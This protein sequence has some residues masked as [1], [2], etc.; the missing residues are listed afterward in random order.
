MKVLAFS[1]VQGTEGHERLFSDPTISLQRW[2]VQ[3]LYQRLQEICQERRCDAVFDLGDT[4][5]DRSAIPVHT[6]NT[7]SEGIAK[8][9]RSTWNVKLIGNHEQTVK[10]TEVNTGVLYRPRFRVVAG[11]EKIALRDGLTLLACSFPES[12]RDL[13]VWIKD[14]INHRRAGEKFLLIGHFQVSGAAMSS[15]ISLDGV[16]LSVLQPI[17]LGLLGHIHRGQSLAGNT[18][19][20]GS[21]FQQNFGESGETKRVAIIDTDTLMVEWVQ[22]EGFPEY[23]TVTLKEF[24]EQDSTSEDRLSVILKTPQEAEEFY[25]HPLAPRA[26]SPVCQY[27]I[28]ESRPS[29]S[30]GQMVTPQA[31][32]SRYVN[33]NPPSA[34]DIALST[35][36]MVEFGL[37]IAGVTE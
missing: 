19:Y 2:R 1:D 34:H 26:V 15:G 23:R 12:D 21:P 8:L 5:D 28:V 16:P 14:A 32:L 10:S 6:L 35:E 30:P 18:H 36:D 27:E 22:I 37:Q 3:R 33:L 13:A 7:I 9:P 17:D 4:T 29:T 20:I 25:A 31:I 11:N 24:I